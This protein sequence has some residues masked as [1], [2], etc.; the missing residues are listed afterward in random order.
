MSS[1]S[2]DYMSSSVDSMGS[3]FTGSE[4]SE[5]ENDLFSRPYTDALRRT[6]RRKASV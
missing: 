6:V 1:N 5:S 3:Q 2:L 4:S